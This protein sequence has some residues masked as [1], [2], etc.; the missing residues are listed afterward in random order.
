MKTISTL[1]KLFGASLLVMA[2][3]S[4]SYAQSNAISAPDLQE[5]TTEDAIYQLSVSQN[6]TKST[7]GRYGLT[8]GSTSQSIIIA[9]DKINEIGS[10]GY[11]VKIPQGTPIGTTVY[12]MMGGLPLWHV[13]VADI[14]GHEGSDPDVAMRP[15]DLSGSTSITTDNNGSGT[16]STSISLPPVVNTGNGASSTSSYKSQPKID[17]YPNPATDQISIVTEGEVLWGVTEIIDITG[18]KILE[19]PTGVSTPANG[20]DRQSVVVSQLKPGTYFLR[21]RTN[22]DVYTKR[23]QVAR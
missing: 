12:V 7:E 23:F 5:A 14:L 16:G 2:G 17:L 22:K 11:T 21:F 10:I 18:K 9:E 6:V 4:S 13:T 15:L 19:I 8:V 3:L 20:I 1:K